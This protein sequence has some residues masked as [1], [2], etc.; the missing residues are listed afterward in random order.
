DLQRLDVSQVTNLTIADRIATAVEGKEGVWLVTWQAEVIDPNGVVP[1]WLDRIGERPADAGDFWGVGLEHWRLNPRKID[2]LHEDALERAVSVNFANQVDLVGMTQ[3]SDTELALF[4][5][6]RQTLPDD[7]LLTLS[8]TDEQGI[9]WTRQDVVRRPGAYLYPP[10]RW[11]VGEVVMTRHPLP[12]QIGTPPGLYLAEIGLGQAA[13]TVGGP[14]EASAAAD[15]VG[16]DVLDKQGR[17]QRRTAL[18]EFVNLS[19]L[20]EPDSGPL[21][22]D[23]DPL[24]DFWPIVAVRRSILPQETAE[25]GDRILLALLWQAGEFHADDISVAFDLVDAKNETFRVGSDLTPS[26]R[27]NLPRW[28]PG[29]VVLGQY[30]LD[31]PPDA[32]PG[33]ATLQLH[34]INQGTYTYDEVF[35]IDQLDIRPTERTFTPPASV[36]L[37]LE[38]N[39]SNRT[40][41]IGA[42][43]SIPSRSDCQVAAPGEAVTLTLYWRSEAAMDKNY[44]VFTHLLGSDET[45]I[46]NADHAPPKPTQGWVPTEIIAD[47]VALTLPTDLPAGDYRL[48]VGLY[49]AADPAFA[50]LPLT[51]GETRLILPQAL[52]IE[53]QMTRN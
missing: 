3:L 26:R 52:S 32:A 21:P 7:L 40:V 41:L 44:T 2:L 31:I 47:T 16:W 17:P 1:F 42:D 51:T 49:D 50:R 20:I 34:L 24:V 15:F 18:L 23:P 30:W 28:Y 48:E 46:V 9:D 6:P 27:Y 19:R 8:L 11:P 13:E 38:A 33:P 43:C 4:W 53:K 37:P 35:T 22:P 10:S 45:V 36:D 14:F 29:A 12:W 39:F 25:P 5:R